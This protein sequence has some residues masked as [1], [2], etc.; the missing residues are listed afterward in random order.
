[1]T[2]NITVRVKETQPTFLKK[3]HELDAVIKKT[4]SGCLLATQT[5]LDALQNDKLSVELRC[6]I[7]TD[8]LKINANMIDQRNREN[9]QRL[10]L[11][12]RHPN[13]EKSAGSGSTA[14]DDENSIPLIDFENVRDV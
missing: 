7:S 8:L 6:K 4:S 13:G 1:M 9:I 5:L 11:E 3:K 12:L 2:T 10:V 14:E